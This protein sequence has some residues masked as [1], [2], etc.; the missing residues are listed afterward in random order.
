MKNVSLITY[1][2]TKN[3]SILLTPL[4]KRIWH[5]SDITHC[6]DYPQ[7]TE[8]LYK[9]DVLVC[10]TT[11]R[12]YEL[13]IVLDYAAVHQ[14]LTTACIGWNNPTTES[15]IY[16]KKYKPQII[17]FDLKSE[18]E[19]DDCAKAVKSGQSF[20]SP[21]VKEVLETEQKQTM[22]LIELYERLSFN[23][24]K[25]FM[26]MLKGYKQEEIAH[27][28]GISKGTASTYCSR[29][30]SKGMVDSTLELF[31]KFSMSDLNM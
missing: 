30:L 9:Y 7:L 26:L 22:T 15:T 16:I 4:L 1:G 28:M 31:R 6:N 17:L 5:T 20:Y 23:E 12:F 27:S 8:E 2:I 10:F 11:M 29:V 13:D 18:S 14:E 25:A 3:Q 21:S 19:L 24:K